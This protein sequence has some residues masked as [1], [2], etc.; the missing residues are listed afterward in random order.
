MTDFSI[1]L[2]HPNDLHFAMS[3]LV[4]YTPVD[5]I[6]N[7]VQNLR[8]QFDS[9][10]QRVTNNATCSDRRLTREIKGLTKDFEFR[11]KQLQNILRFFDEN[12]TA[13]DK[14]LY[15]DLHKH[16][17]EGR[18]SEVAPVVDECKYLIKVLDKVF[19]VV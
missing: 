10:K 8:D 16:R 13:I 18:I 9:G 5:E 2:F 11:K 1:S 4:S 7:I 3:S 14:A 19:T 17:I 6:P 12:A 15:D